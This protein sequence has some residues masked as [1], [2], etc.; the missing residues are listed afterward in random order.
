MEISRK[1][2][3]SRES[4]SK[5]WRERRRTKKK[6]HNVTMVYLEK[7]GMELSES[8]K[9]LIEKC[10][11]KHICCAD[12][13]RLRAGPFVDTN[14]NNKR[15]KKM[16]LNLNSKTKPA[17]A[18]HDGSKNDSDD[19]ETAAAAAAAAAVADSDDNNNKA[20]R[21]R[22][23]LKRLHEGDCAFAKNIKL[24]EMLQR[25]L[26]SALVADLLAHHNFRMDS[27]LLQIALYHSVDQ[28]LCIPVGASS[29]GLLCPLYTAAVTQLPP[30]SQL[31]T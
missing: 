24:L 1:Q 3:R 17:A 4:R 20:R 30:K 6:T 23:L 31:C 7:H 28:P 16:N 25:L 14:N 27:C 2:M 9:K 15:S 12:G 22:H 13:H 8:T 26:V 29:N 11:E 18:D 5:C 21:L 10:P 19:E